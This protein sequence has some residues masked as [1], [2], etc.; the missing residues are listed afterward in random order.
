M[1]DNPFSNP[2]LT[3]HG[4]DTIRNGNSGLFSDPVL[5]S[6]QEI[7]TPVLHTQKRDTGYASSFWFIGGLIFL[8]LLFTKIRI[9]YSKLL[10][11]MFIGFF[12]YRY[13]QKIYDI[14]NSS[15]NFG[16]FL[17][18]ILFLVSIPLFLFQIGVF[19]GYIQVADHKILLLL[20]AAMMGFFAIRIIL[21]HFIGAVFKGTKEANEYN[22]NLLMHFKVAGMIIFP[23]TI[24]IPYIFSNVVPTL[25]AIGFIVLALSYISGIFRG[26]KILYQKH[27]SV[28]YMILYLCALE[29]VPAL[30]MLKYAVIK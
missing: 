7:N 13:I 3:K 26:I 6:V 24:C 11:D 30:I 28:F 19:K 29:I 15:Y 14:K 12:R 4:T 23:L 17:M 9:S 18:N 2:I 21:T 1:Q 27:V 8:L 22:F 20:I 10:S 25:S 16:Y 5:T